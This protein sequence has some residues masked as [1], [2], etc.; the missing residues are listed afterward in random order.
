[1]KHNRIYHS[2][3]VLA[4]TLCLTSLL[5]ACGEWIDVTPEDRIV[6]T[7]VF[8]RTKGY[9]K[10]VNGLYSLLNQSSLYGCD[11]S[12]GLIDA[13]A[14]MYNIDKLHHNYADL[15]HGVYTSSTAKGQVAP[16]W[17]KGYNLIVNANTIIDHTADADCP[18]YEL[19]KKR[20]K[21]EA[22]AV[23]AFM[24]FDLLRLFGPVPSELSKQAIPYQTSSKLEVKPLLTGQQ[25]LDSVKVDLTEALQ[26]LSES[27]PLLYPDKYD[28]DSLF[29]RPYRM[30]YFAV[31]A[32]LARVCLYAGNKDEALRYAT[33]VITEGEPYFP[34][35]T[36]EAATSPD[37]PDRIFLSEVLFGLY[38][39][40]R[41]NHVHNSF[42]NPSLSAYSILTLQGNLGS[43]RLV[44]FYDDQN[45]YRFK[46][47]AME[48][49]DGGNVLY[50]SKFQNVSD[51]GRLNYTIPLVRMSEMYLIAAECSTDMED[52]NYYLNALRNRRN[53]F[54]VTVTQEN[55]RQYLTMEYRK[56]MLGEGQ[57]FFYFKRCE[58]TR[59]PLAEAGSG[60]EDVSLN[61]YV[62]PLPDSETSMRMDLE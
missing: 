22:L 31:K 15:A 55:L 29:M 37:T 28:S 49:G 16:I 54:S 36:A 38:D 20:M 19:D 52:A 21:A 1:M 17:D 9:E 51:G 48:I 26:M 42:F 2:T 44:S 50:H 58:M 32:I 34:A 43:G 5:S 41:R 13:M 6:E 53:S 8:S 30:N 23:R 10:A 4:L 62:V 24:H 3:G 12:A 25:V 45:D 40:S 35:T 57:L 18:L 27:E 39:T 60:D 11:M 46:I 33:E 59:L 56:E 47:W 14:H 61:N 7:T